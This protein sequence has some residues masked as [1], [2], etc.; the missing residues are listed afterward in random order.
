MEILAEDIWKNNNCSNVV[1]HHSYICSLKI[2]TNG[3]LVPQKLHMG[4]L[5]S[6]ETITF[7]LVRFVN[8]YWGG[9]FKNSCVM[10][11]I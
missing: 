8:V 9:I 11:T 7:S 10:Y 6:L 3:E 1:L 5:S 4:T 2:A